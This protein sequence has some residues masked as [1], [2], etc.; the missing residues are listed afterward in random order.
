MATILLFGASGPVGRFLLPLLTARQHVVPV[1]RTPASADTGWLCAD[2]NDERVA[3]PAA[4]AV[5][6]LGPLDA[7]AAWL[8]RRGD[9]APRHI[10]ALSSMSANSKRDSTDAAE[11]ALAERLRDA[12]ARVLRCATGFGGTATLLRPTLI[13]GAGT[14]R[15]LAPI[16]RFAR[17]Y[18][19][20]PIPIGARGLRQPVHARDLANACLAALDAPATHGQTYPVGGGERL[21]F[22]TLLR[23]LRNSLP[24]IVVPVPVP[25]FVLALAARWGAAGSLGRAAVQRLREPLIADNSAAERDFHYAPGPFDASA[26]LPD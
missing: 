13:Y 19:V 10:L 2:I 14:D 3:W 11:R 22:D 20:L 4:D 5:I 21:R 26:V 15:S 6:S 17:R 24:G 1:S 12:E 8:E 16:A 23:R 25:M 18:R 9:T 7:F